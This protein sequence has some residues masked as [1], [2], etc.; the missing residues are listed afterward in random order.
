MQLMNF[1]KARKLWK[2]C[3]G[4]ET[5]PPQATAQQAEDFEVRTA[6]VLSVLSQTVSNE[7]LH[8]IAA[9]SVGRCSRYR[10]CARSNSQQVVPPRT[11][12]AR[13]EPEVDACAHSEQGQSVG[14]QAVSTQNRT[15]ETVTYKTEKDSMVETHVEHRVTIHSASGGDIGHDA[16]LS[17]M[18]MEVTKMNLDF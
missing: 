7:Y 14:S 13:A 6:C 17:V 1:L 15:V 3:L 11:A 16:E 8:L 5:L 9:Q 4:T 2:L 12:E 10:V 18:I